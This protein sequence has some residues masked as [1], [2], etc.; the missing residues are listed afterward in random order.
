[1]CTKSLVVELLQL[2]LCLDQGAKVFPPGEV[3]PAWSISISYRHCNACLQHLVLLRAWGFPLHTLINEAFGLQD[4]LYLHFT[5]IIFFFRQI[6]SSFIICFRIVVRKPFLSQDPL[7]WKDS[8]MIQTLASF[9]VNIYDD[10]LNRHHTLIISGVKK[11][12]DSE[13]FQ[14]S[15]YQLPFCGCGPD[16][17]N[18]GK[19][20]FTFDFRPGGIESF[21][22]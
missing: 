4:T 11:I 2:L 3:G 1:M 16:K 20:G 8:E 15:V 9:K 19:K 13:M 12:A 17:C 21:M 14:V 7:R 18:L 6:T 10:V 22:L 5:Q